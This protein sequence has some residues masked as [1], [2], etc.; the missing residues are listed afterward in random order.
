MKP[1]LFTMPV[2]PI[3]ASPPGAGAS[4]IT[5][6]IINHQQGG[7]NVCSPGANFTAEGSCGAHWFA[8]NPHGP[9]TQSPEPVYT[10]N[11]TLVNGSAARFRTRQRPQLVFA[12]DGFTPTFLFNAGSFDGYN[13]DY[14][15][16]GHTYAFAFSN[17]TKLARQQDL[18]L[19]PQP[20]A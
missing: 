12:K 10:E 7:G 13:F 1:F 16:F 19:R 11:V 15:C 18:D 5:W 4:D 20:S 9:W 2:N 6:H 17:K 14:S 3:S 8:H